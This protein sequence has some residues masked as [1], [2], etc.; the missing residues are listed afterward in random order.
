MHASV[1]WLVPQMPTAAGM[2]LGSS[3]EPGTQDRTPT[4][5]AETQLLEPSLL[6]PR[7][8]ISKMLEAGA[9][10]GCLIQAFRC[11]LWS[12]P[13]ANTCPELDF[14]RLNPASAEYSGQLS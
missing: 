7:A 8:R 14:G 4:W 5:L 6:P 9:G 12:S 13:L 3:Q 11:G 2:G 10:A 1:C